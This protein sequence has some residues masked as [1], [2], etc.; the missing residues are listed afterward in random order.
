MDVFLV[1]AGCFILISFLPSLNCFESA[2]G[3]GI[4]NTRNLLALQYP[5]KPRAN[6]DD[7][8]DQFTADLTIQWTR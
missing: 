5:G 6:I 7:D 2:S 8:P 1:I 3:I 4:A